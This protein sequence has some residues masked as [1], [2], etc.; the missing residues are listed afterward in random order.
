MYGLNWFSEALIMMVHSLRS[1]CINIC[2]N[3][4]NF[5]MAAGNSQLALAMDI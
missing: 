2:E 1:H 3:A 4:S 5:M